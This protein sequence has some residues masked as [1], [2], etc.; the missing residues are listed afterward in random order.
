MLTQYRSQALSI[1]ILDIDFFKRVNDRF[2][3]L[4]GDDVLRCFAENMRKCCRKEDIVARLGGEEFAILLPMPARRDLRDMQHRHHAICTRGK[5]GRISRTRGS[6][7]LPGK[8]GREKQG[9]YSGKS[10]LLR[11]RLRGERRRRRHVRHSGRGRRRGRNV[12]SPPGSFI[13]NGG[14]GISRRQGRTA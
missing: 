5:D 12:R 8:G 14:I 10:I 2:G 6:G 7:S 1:L 4:C 13:M 9:A 11:P 3:H